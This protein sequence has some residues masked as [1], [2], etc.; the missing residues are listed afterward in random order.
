MEPDAGVVHDDV[1]KEE[2]TD[3]AS[4]QGRENNVHDAVPFSL[5]LIERTHPL[6]TQV[7][8]NT[9]SKQK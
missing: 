9:A 1:E 5:G 3:D 8:D 4:N 2:I 7:E 6:A